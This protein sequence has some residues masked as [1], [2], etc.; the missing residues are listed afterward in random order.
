MRLLVAVGLETEQVLTSRAAAAS[1]VTEAGRRG[2]MVEVEE[3]G[4]RG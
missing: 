3:G 4:R 1:D 2:G